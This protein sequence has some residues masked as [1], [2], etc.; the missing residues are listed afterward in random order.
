MKL[1]YKGGSIVGLRGAD[2]NR[3][4]SGAAKEISAAEAPKRIPV[5]R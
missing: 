4:Q 2:R 5:K 3:I 1:S